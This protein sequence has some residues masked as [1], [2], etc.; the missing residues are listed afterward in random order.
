MELLMKLALV[1]DAWPPQVNGV[2]T[3]LS[4]TRRC[5]EELGQQVAVFA[6]NGHRTLPC[7]TY[8][9]IR[10]A[11]WP[12]RRLAA[13]IDE[14][15]PDALHIATEG[16]LGLAAARYC[17]ARSLAFTTSY[18]TQFP[19]YL[20]KRFPIPERLTYAL[21][22]AHHR[23]AARTLVPTE[24]QRRELVD[25]GFRNLVLWPRGVDTATFRPCG[26]DHLRKRRP[27]FT[28]LG[29]V[30]T[31]KNIESFLTLDLPG[32]KVVI[33]DGP[34]RAML[35]ARYPTAAFVGYRFGA[36]LT[37]LLSSADV[38]VFPSRTDTFGLVMLEAMACGTPV[39]AYPVIGPI[40][41]VTPGV[42]GY[43][44]N[45][46]RTAALAALTLDRDACRRAVEDRTWERASER[47]LSHLLRASDGAALVRPVRTSSRAEDDLAVG[48]CA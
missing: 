39:A 45:D 32:T 28:Y 13:A 14:F 36:S 6:S 30:A 40:D 43:L 25:H 19:Q 38:L 31:E 8:P 44:D 17:E 42:T 21:L 33:G 9:E 23:R 5:L 37:Q 20:R 10:L 22:R 12:R 3:T 4:R 29:R 11:L 48:S 41:V 2:V 15:E 46:L 34:D 35:E 27:I 7:P 16:P 1:T 26:R 18:H 47:F 24:H